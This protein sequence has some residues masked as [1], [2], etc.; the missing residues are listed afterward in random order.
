MEARSGSDGCGD[1]DSV[2]TRLPLQLPGGIPGRAGGRVGFLLG[3]GRGRGRA[4]G[5]GPVCL[6]PVRVGHSFEFGLQRARPTDI[7]TVHTRVAEGF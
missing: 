7:V 5:T 1:R 3:R 4:D 2:P 6:G